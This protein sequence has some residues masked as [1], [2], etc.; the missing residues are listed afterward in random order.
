MLKIENVGFIE[1]IFFIASSRNLLIAQG[2][3]LV[4]TVQAFLKGKHL[5][6][7]FFPSIQMYV[8]L[9]EILAVFHYFDQKYKNNFQLS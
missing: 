8:C 1:K 6:F 2:N 5:V 3:D 9:D 4:S 7:T